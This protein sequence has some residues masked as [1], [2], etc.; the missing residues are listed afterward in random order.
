MICMTTTCHPGASSWKKKIFKVDLKAPSF[1]ILLLFSQSPLDLCVL[2]YRKQII[3]IN[4]NKTNSY[5]SLSEVASSIPGMKWK[6]ALD[7]HW[8]RAPV[9]SAYAENVI[10]ISAFLCVAKLKEVANI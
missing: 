3:F 9:S 5:F 2:Q 7:Q 1:Y 6:Y 10:T 4:K 8:K